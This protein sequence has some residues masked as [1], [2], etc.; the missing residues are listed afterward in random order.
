MIVQIQQIATQIERDR[1]PT[2]LLHRS[3]SELSLRCKSFLRPLNTVVTPLRIPGAT[4]NGTKNPNKKDAVMYIHS[5][6]LLSSLTAIT[7]PCIYPVERGKEQ[8]TRVR[9]SPFTQFHLGLEAN[10]RDGVLHA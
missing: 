1:R 8:K 7:P 6:T 3:E 5:R 2:S 4:S 9:L 10:A